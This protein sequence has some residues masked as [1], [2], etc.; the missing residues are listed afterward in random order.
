MGLMI[1]VCIPVTT[2][3]CPGAV[4]QAQANPKDMGKCFGSETF[5]VGIPICSAGTLLY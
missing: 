1:W 5:C 3:C 2:L 4:S